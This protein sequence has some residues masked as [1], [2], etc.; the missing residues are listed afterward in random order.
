MPQLVEGQPVYIQGSGAKPYEL[1]NTGGVY[2]CSCPAWRNQGLPIDKRTCKHLK[3]HC[4][5]AAEQARTGIQS[6]STAKTVKAKKAKKGSK[7]KAHNGVHD[8]KVIT[9]DADY[10]QTVLDRAAAE[11]RDLRQD[12]KAK[13]HGPPI[14][15]AHKFEDYDDLDPTGW[16]Y[17]EKLDGV[18]A[19][20]NGQDFVSRQGNVFFAPDWFK[21]PLPKN[22]I[23]DGE[24]WIGRQMFQKTLSV[25][26][27][28][29]WGEG[30][31]DVRYVIFDVPSREEGFEE[32]LQAARD[33]AAVMKAAHVQ[34][35]PHD[36]VQ[37]RKHLLDELNQAAAAG[38]EGLMIRKPGSMYRK[39]R[40]S[41]LLKVKPFQDTEGVVIAHKP[42]KGRHKGVLGAVVLRLSTGVEFDL[43]TGFTDAE[44]RSP[45]PI[46]AN[47]TFRYTELTNEGKPKCTS[48][49][50]IRDYE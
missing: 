12:E 11:G 16:W 38:A 4:G 35:H 48:F 36:V 13:L 20:W 15:L 32:R 39:G 2:S 34:A 27:R 7:A 5:D 45:P 47:I 31:R 50:C 23:L 24:L 3:K 21:A 33:H 22:E 6:S 46:G 8:G 25:V 29:D 44:R 40:S 9:A 42:G 43:G 28:H 19:Y 17:S 18:R 30:A 26:R 41:E 1:K 14:L 10:A 37:S 49:I